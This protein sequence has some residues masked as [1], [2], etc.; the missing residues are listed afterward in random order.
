MILQFWVVTFSVLF[1]A[2]ADENHSI[3]IKLNDL[4]HRFTQMFS[5]QFYRHT[6]QV[7]DRV[8]ALKISIDTNLLELDQQIQQALDGIQSNESSSSASATKPPG[9]TTI[10]IGSEPRVPAL[11]ERER[12]GGDWLVVMH[13]YDGSV[14]F[15]R[16]WAEYR[17]GFGMV[18][19]E[20]WYGLERLHQLTKEKSYE[21]MV[22]MEDFNGSLKYAWY[23]KFVVGPEEQRYA[24]VELGTFN[25]TTDGDSLKPHKGSGFSTYDNDDFGCSN[26]YAKGGWWYYSGKCYGS[27]LTGIWKNELAYSSIVWM[28]FSDV[29][30]TPLKLVRMMIRPK[31]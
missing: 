20:F 8:S 6:Q 5:Q 16:T 25:G 30:N 31:N 28:K 4:D 10:P 3:L 26:K 11:Y 1:A 21:L 12:Y 22:E 24:L 29:S 2:R 27:S 23:D 18:G 19:Q 9:L 17:D 14:K 15:D 13:R 7:T